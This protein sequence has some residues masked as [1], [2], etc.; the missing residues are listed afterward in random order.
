MQEWYSFGRENLVDGPRGFLIRED[1]SIS[2]AGFA[3]FIFWKKVFGRVPVKGFLAALRAE[4][5]DL[6]I[7]HGLGGRRIDVDLHTANGV[8][9]HSKHGGSFRSILRL[10]S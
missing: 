5:V 2:W 7:H 9:Y 10:T 8:F 4:V 3:I 1:L 6:S